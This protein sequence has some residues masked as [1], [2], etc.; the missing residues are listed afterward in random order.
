MKKLVRDYTIQK[1]EKEGKNCIVKKVNEEEFL[2]ALKASLLEEVHTLIHVDTKEEM[3]SEMADVFEILDAFLEVYNIEYVQV[4][5]KK[6]S[7]AQSEGRYMQRIVLKI[8]E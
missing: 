8:N 4:F 6:V 7:K 3:Q 5:A 2:T 1:M